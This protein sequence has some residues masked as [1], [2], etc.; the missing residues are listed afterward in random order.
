MH[1]EWFNICFQIFKFFFFSGNTPNIKIYIV[2]ESIKNTS[3]ILISP[4][5]RTHSNKKI[6]ISAGSDK[7]F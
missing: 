7:P 3:F 6:Y 4:V 5:R 1:D 2:N